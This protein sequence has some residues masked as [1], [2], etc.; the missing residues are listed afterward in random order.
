MPSR[1]PGQR[2]VD[3]RPAVVHQMQDRNAPDN[4]SEI[5]DEPPVA[6]PP[7][8]S[9]AHRHQRLRCGL[10]GHLIDGGEEIGPRG[11]SHN[12]DG[13]LPPRHIRRIQ[14]L[15][16]KAASWPYHASTRCSPY[17]AHPPG[18]YAQITRV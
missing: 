4:L 8:I 14:R 11:P 13:R 5:G 9:I 1:N 6:A 17:S 12:P 2:E 16:T 10:G 18:R 3:R 15:P 7:G